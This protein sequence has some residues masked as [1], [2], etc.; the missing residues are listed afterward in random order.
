MLKRCYGKK[1]TESNQ[2]KKVR[3]S[4]QNQT[5]TFNDDAISVKSEKPKPTNFQR[6]EP[7]FENADLIRSSSS[8]NAHS[9]YNSQRE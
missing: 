2:I 8:H 4:C 9:F 5:Q 7:L 3:F 1:A 6:F